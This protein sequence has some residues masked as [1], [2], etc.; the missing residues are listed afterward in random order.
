MK[1]TIEDLRNHMFAQ[2]EKLSDCEPENLATELKR[3][4]SIA[5]LGAVIVESAKAEVAFV[6]AT[7]GKLT[8]TTFISKDK[9]LEA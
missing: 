6:K 9:M 3:S 8:T 5:A 2:L 1:N 7:K 4:E